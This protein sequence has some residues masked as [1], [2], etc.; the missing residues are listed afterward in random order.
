MPAEGK[1]WIAGKEVAGLGKPFTARD[2]ATGQEIERVFREASED[3]VEAA[4][5][6]ASLCSIVFAATDPTR[7]AALLNAIA[8]AIAE[9]GEELIETAMSETGL[10]RPRLEGER[11]RTVGQFRLFATCLREGEFVRVRLDSAQPDRSPAPKPDLRLQMLALG[12]VAVFGASN[13]PLAFSVAGGD[14]ASAL[15]A[16]CPVV[17]KGHPAHPGTSEIMARAVGQ[18]IAAAKFEAGIFSMLQSAGP[19]IGM[20][21]VTDPRIKAVGFTGSAAAG[22]ALV[23]AA[24]ARR[25]PIP[26][27][28]EMS[29]INPVLLLPSRLSSGA[30]EVAE[31]FVASLTLGSGQF[32]TNP[33]LVLAINNSD[34]DRF[35][36]AAAKAVQARD[37]GVM[38]TS[39]IGAA[40]ATAVEGVAA[41]EGV[42]VLAEGCSASNRATA[43]LMRVG[44]ARF[45]SDLSIHAEMFGPAALVVTCADIEEMRAVLDALE[46]QLTVALHFDKGDHAAVAELLPVAQR[47]AGRVLANGFG[48]GV[49]VSPAMVHG[50]PWPASSDSRTTSV[51]TLAIE[52][53]LRPVCLQD[54][55]EAL[56]PPALR[57]SNPWNLPR[58]KWD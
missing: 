45:M 24:S 54:F 46:G 26:V 20:A 5:A 58:R 8:D 33:G 2:A 19:E 9:T 30:E 3:Q 29:S 18:G 17:V 41:R 34:C 7:R 50:G 43:R 31:G 42:E 44:A 14:T 27:Y 39:G 15:A 25:E 35:C 22:K 52:R 1:M 32:C 57:D 11:A 16:G 56:L 40:Y 28:A 10:P 37:P 4:V 21:L 47:R 13:F 6:S 51:G 12:P 48:T 36:S 49:E 38:L 55:P 53:F 23:T